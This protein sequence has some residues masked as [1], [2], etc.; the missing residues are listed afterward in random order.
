MTPTKTSTPQPGKKTV[1]ATGKKMKNGEALKIVFFAGKVLFNG[2]G[3][4]A[5]NLLNIK[6]RLN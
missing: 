4:Q 3:K 1:I 2:D 5:A 6:R